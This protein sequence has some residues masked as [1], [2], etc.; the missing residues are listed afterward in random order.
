MFNY[1]DFNIKGYLNST[2]LVKDYGGMLELERIVSY[3]SFVCGSMFLL[4]PNNLEF[5]CCDET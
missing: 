5:F 3:S 2:N 1:V 4:I